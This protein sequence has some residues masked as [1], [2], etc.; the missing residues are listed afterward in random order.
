MVVQLFTGIHQ[1]L[2]EG[3][4]L[5]E[6]VE[7]EPLEDLASFALPAGQVCQAPVDLFV[8]EGIALRRRVTSAF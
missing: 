6:A 3:D 8:G 1:A 4:R 5:G 2:Q 7:T